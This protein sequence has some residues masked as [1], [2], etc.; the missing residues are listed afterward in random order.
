MANLRR[1]IQNR[2]MTPYLTSS[3]ELLAEQK[4]DISEEVGEDLSF[5][6][7][8]SA[9]RKVHAQAELLA[10]VDVP[11]LIVGESGSGKEIVARLIHKRSDRS[12]NKF[13]KLSCA[14]VDP[15]ILENELF[16]E[17]NGGSPD[18]DGNWSNPIASCKEG[19]LLLDEIDEM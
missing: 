4:E 15:E 12:A 17:N 9:M 6:A 8:S 2:V 18:A 14:A 3:I 5:V 1:I 13:L 10:R 11:I 19:T 16:E 7:A